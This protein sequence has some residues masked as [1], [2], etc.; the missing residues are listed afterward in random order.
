M[1][2]TLSLSV[3]LLIILASCSSPKDKAEKIVITVLKEN[4]NDPTSFDL[5]NSTSETLAEYETRTKGTRYYEQ[6]LPTIRTAKAK[7]SQ[8]LY[9][10]T[11]KYRAKNAFDALMLNNSTFVYGVDAT[12]KPFVYL[13]EFK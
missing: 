4:M 12:E 7:T 5:I 11:L 6:N 1:H 10:V 13:F 8:P 9:I 2:R 3:L